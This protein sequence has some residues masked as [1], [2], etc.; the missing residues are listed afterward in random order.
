MDKV[1]HIRAFCSPNGTFREV[2]LD[3]PATDY[4]LLDALEQLQPEDGKRPYLEFHAVEEYDYLD[5]R[6][7]RRRAV[8]LP[9]SAMW[10]GTRSFLISMKRWIFDPASRPIPSF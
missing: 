8:H 10:S 3:L 4:E 5:E 1:F 7:G 2:E 9:A 6:I